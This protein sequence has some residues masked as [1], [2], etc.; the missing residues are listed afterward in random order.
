[1]A[2]GKLYCGCSGYSIQEVDLAKSTSG[3]FYSGTRKLLGKQTIHS[4]L[5]HDSLLF[6]GGSSVDGTAGKVFSLPS[7]AISGSL[8]TGFDIQRMAV[9]NDFICCHS[10]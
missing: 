4:L 9:S 6:A 3:T 7:K 2:G 8:S 10:T 1:M 5:I